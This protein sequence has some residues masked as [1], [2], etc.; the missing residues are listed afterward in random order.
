MSISKHSNNFGYL[1]TFCHKNVKGTK[2]LSFHSEHNIP[3][4]FLSAAILSLYSA[5]LIEHHKDS[6]SVC[7]SYLSTLQLLRIKILASFSLFLL[8]SLLLF[9]N[10]ICKIESRQIVLSAM[11]LLCCRLYNSIFPFP[12][13]L[14]LSDSGKNYYE[15]RRL[16]KRIIMS[17]NY[18]LASEKRR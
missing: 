11:Y 7:P 5:T 8:V 9:H 14:S 18:L 10:Y 13:A 4:L 17:M 15:M 12:I 2:Y 16:S 3:N 6:F 1:T